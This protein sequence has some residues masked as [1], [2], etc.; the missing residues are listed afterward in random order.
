MDSKRTSKSG[1]N[2]DW[3]IDRKIDRK[4]G[5][6]INWKI[7]RKIVVEDNSNIESH[8]RRITNVVYHNHYSSPHANRRVE[9]RPRAPIEPCSGRTLA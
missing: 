4:I 9:F 3:E 8:S 1:N 5:R 6:K 2:S 7:D